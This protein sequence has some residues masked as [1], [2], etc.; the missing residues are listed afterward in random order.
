MTPK[1]QRRADCERKG[2]VPL[3][4]VL[5]PQFVARATENPLRREQP[6]VDDADLDEAA[7]E[8]G[9]Q[10]VAPFILG[11]LRVRLPPAYSA[12]KRL[13]D[14]SLPL[15]E[16]ARGAHV[17]RAVNLSRFERTDANNRA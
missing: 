15:D 16:V 2:I 11:R 7:R 13:P 5:D 10:L 4:I 14:V 1:C 8:I 3:Q 12:A 9:S 6:A 17:P